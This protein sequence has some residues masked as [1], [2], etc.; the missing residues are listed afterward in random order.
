LGRA[1]AQVFGGLLAVKAVKQFPTRIR[2]VK[3]W[4][5]VRGLQEAMI[6][7]DFNG[8]QTLY[9]REQAWSHC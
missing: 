3:E 7:A 6:L 8:W 1:L 4:L 5:P 9:L 2:Q